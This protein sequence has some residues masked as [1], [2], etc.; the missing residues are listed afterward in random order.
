M[1][2]PDEK[3]THRYQ[4]ALRFDIEGADLVDVLPIAFQATPGGKA[5]A[6]KVYT[7]EVAPDY[8]SKAWKPR[9]PAGRLVLFWSPYDLATL[10]PSPVGPDDALTLV[11]A[12]LREADYGPEPQHDGSNRKGCRVWNESFGYIDG[13]YQAFVAIEPVWLEFHK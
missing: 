6:W 5:V 9:T 1:P 12:W 3:V 7:E 4:G 2:R 13:Q 11:T 8:R 10:L